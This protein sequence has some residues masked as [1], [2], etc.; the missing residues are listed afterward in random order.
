MR[1]AYWLRRICAIF[2]APPIV[3]CALAL[4]L[5]GLPA[6]S[7]APGAGQEAITIFACDNGV[8]VD[9]VLPIE[10]VGLD[11]RQTFEAHHFAGPTSGLTHVGLGWGSRDFYLATPRWR[12]FRPHFAFKALLWDDTVLHVEL[13]QQPSAE[14]DCRQWPASPASY[15]ALARFVQESMQRESGRVLPVGSGYGPNDAFFQARGQYTPV[16]TC[17]QWSGRALALAGAPVGRWTPFSF[18]VT[19]R[20]PPAEE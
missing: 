19:W 11:W 3:Y 13:R 4:V 8:H 16:A 6:Q 17:N 7:R 14:G 5:A 2:I 15:L 1:I 12:D 18:L 20:L 9:L 10:A